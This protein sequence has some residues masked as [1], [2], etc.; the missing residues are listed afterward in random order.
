MA[1][2]FA[3]S[4][5]GW[6]CGDYF[7]MVSLPATGYAAFFSPA[8]TFAHRARCAAAILFLPA[9]DI[10]CLGFIFPA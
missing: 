10:V 2:P 5:K 1:H 3:F 7:R 4:A 8:L 6:D 9:T